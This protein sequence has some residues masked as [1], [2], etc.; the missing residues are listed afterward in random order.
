MCFEILVHDAIPS[1]RW[2]QKPPRLETNERWGVAQDAKPQSLPLQTELPEGTVT[3]DGPQRGGRAGGSFTYGSGE[4]QGWWLI[5]PAPQTIYPAGGGL[6][7]VPKA[8]QQQQ[9]R[10]RK[11]LCQSEEQP[12]EER[13]RLP[14]HVGPR[15]PPTPAHRES[16]SC[17]GDGRSWCRSVPPRT[18]ERG[19]PGPPPALERKQ[20]PPGE[21]NT[22]ATPL[23]TPAQPW[24][25]PGGIGEAEEGSRSPRQKQ[26]EPLP[27]LSRAAARKPKE[28]ERFC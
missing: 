20:Q 16:Q 1:Q 3:Q 22:L 21:S 11:I 4:A 14:R 12:L 6:R 2:P 18:E 17:R 7:R 19:E 25:G 28:K 23:P 26:Q 9:A 5:L 15:D 8:Q 24:L 13:K 10:S 27:G